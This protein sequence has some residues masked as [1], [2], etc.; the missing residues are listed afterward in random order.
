MLAEIGAALGSAKSLLEISKTISDV[1]RQAEIA[2]VSLEFNQKLLA[3]AE[4][5]QSLFDENTSLRNSVSSLEGKLQERDNFAREAAKYDL[6]EVG[7]GVFA[8]VAND[9]AKIDQST[10]KFCAKCFSDGKLSMLQQTEEPR[11]T[12]GLECHGCACKVS[13]THYL[14]V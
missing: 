8:Y 1:S 7:T 11:R 9:S 14:M 4:K 13:F 3:L 12:I 2:S 10:H 5:C 6:R